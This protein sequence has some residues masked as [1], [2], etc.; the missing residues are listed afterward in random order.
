MPLNTLEVV[1]R[2]SEK[3]LQ[4]CENLNKLTHL[5]ANKYLATGG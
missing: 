4:V 2:V 5:T 1:G 3:Q